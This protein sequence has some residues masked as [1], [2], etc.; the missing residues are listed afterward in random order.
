[1]RTLT[2]SS[3]GE[4]VITHFEGMWGWHSHSRNGDLGVL[5]DSRKLRVQ[6][7]G[8]KHLAL[9]FS[10]YCW[11]GLEESYKFASDLISIGGLNKELWTSKF[12]GVQIGTLSGLLLGSPGKK[13]HLGVGAAELHKEYYMGEGGGF[14]RIWAVVSHVNPGWLM[15][16]PSTENAPESE[17]TNLLVGLIQVW[18]TK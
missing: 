14:P 7:Q 8:S 12:P 2:F 4:S 17:L 10:L 9:K 18:V 13:C 16:C 1:M 15:A 11:K 6:L 3:S 5:L